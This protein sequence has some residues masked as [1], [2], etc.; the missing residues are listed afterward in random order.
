MIQKN[1]RRS[2]GTYDLFIKIMFSSSLLEI[3]KFGYL[4]S[5]T[6][7]NTLLWV[8]ELSSARWRGNW[9][10]YQDGREGPIGQRGW[11]IVTCPQQEVYRVFK[12]KCAEKRRDIYLFIKI[13]FSSSEQRIRW[14][15]FENEKASAMF[16]PAN[17]PAR[18]SIFKCG[19]S[20]KIFVR[21]SKRVIVYS[22]WVN[23]LKIEYIFL[24]RYVIKTCFYSEN[25]L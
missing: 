18:N 13:M 5:T 21:T 19:R 12:N 16:A 1:A 23:I 25:L 8:S 2:V 15:L 17:R 24:A 9:R 3:V 6:P 4:N 11:V 20:D 22:H 14:V 10:L 7:V